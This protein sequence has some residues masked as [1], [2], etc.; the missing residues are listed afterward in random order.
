MA[1]AKGWDASTPDG[2]ITPA[3]DIDVEIQDTKVAVGERLAEFVPEW[4]DDLAQ[5]KKL[6]IVY[7]DLASRPS[8]PDFAGELYFATDTGTLFVAD[9][10]P[11][12][13]SVTTIVEEGDDEVVSTSFSMSAMLA[14]SYQIPVDT[15]WHKLSGWTVVGSRGTFY[16]GG[17]PTRFVAPASGD[18]KV[19]VVFYCGLSAGNVVKGAYG[20]NGGTPSADETA[21]IISPDSMGVGVPLEFIVY[22]MATGSYVELYVQNELGSA[23][24]PWIYAGGW[25]HVSM[26]RLP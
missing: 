26:H 10:T 1:Y 13:V 12:W 21:R 17:Q 9:G 4:A 3:A 16:S 8:T 22:S 23:A 19:S 15:N 5:P 14:S 20:I 11:A 25:T 18:Y 7:G 24:A 6:A 2:A